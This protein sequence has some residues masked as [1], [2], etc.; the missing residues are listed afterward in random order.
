MS[1]M[2]QDF[3]NGLEKAR[4]RLADSQQAQ[5]P[6]ENTTHTVRIQ[7]KTDIAHQRQDL[8]AFTETFREI[9]TAL[10]TEQKYSDKETLLEPSSVRDQ[11]FPMELQLSISPYTSDVADLLEHNE[12]ECTSYL[13]YEFTIGNDNNIEISAFL[14]TSQPN[15]FMFI[16]HG[17]APENLQYFSQTPEQGIAIALQ[18][19]EDAVKLLQEWQAVQE[20]RDYTDARKILTEQALHRVNNKSEETTKRDRKN[21]ASLTS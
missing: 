11:Y 20:T 18:D 6:S 4:K 7:N 17:R 5:P 16:N 1:D 13:R 10:I 21:K 12:H 15:D 2:L 19:I 3:N 8:Q 14:S 9:T